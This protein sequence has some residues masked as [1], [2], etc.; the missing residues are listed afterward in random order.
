MLLGND[1]HYFQHSHKESVQ[2][3]NLNPRGTD[4]QEVCK[5]YILHT[6]HQRV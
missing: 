2:N 1:L 5:W 3:I 4:F 6:L